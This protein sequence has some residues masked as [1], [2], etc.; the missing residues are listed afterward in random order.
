MADSFEDTIQIKRG[1]YDNGQYVQKRLMVIDYIKGTG[2]NN[3]KDFLTKIVVND[4][5]FGFQL[6]EF[7]ITKNAM[8]FIDNN[9]F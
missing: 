7:S 8:E 6:P 3:L 4:L 2:I 9:R 1:F 5:N